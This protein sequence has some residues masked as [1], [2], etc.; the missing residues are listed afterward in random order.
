M[1]RKEANMEIVRLIVNYLNMHPDLRFSQALVNLDVSF[2][3]SKEMGLYSGHVLEYNE[4]PEVT[5]ERVKK[6]LE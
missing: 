2:D 4:E 3:L 5:L 6:A 1:S